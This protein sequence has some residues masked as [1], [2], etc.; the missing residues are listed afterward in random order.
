M[1]TASV[2][3]TPFTRWT[4]SAPTGSS[5]CSLSKISTDGTTITPPI[6]PIRIDAVGLTQSAPAVIATSPARQPFRVIERSGL[7][8]I[9]M[10]DSI[11]PITPALAPNIVVQS[12]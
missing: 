5:S 12:T 10:P 9:A 8:R 2:P 6:R 11:A 3:Q 7:R 1:P 4:D